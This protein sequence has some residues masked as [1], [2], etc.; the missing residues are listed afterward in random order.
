MQD[1]DENMEIPILKKSW[2]L[3]W[4][5]QKTISN[6]TFTSI[7][8][9]E[10]EFVQIVQIFIIFLTLTPKLLN[11][12]KFRVTAWKYSNIWNNNNAILPPY[13]EQFSKVPE[14]FDTKFYNFLITYFDVRHD[15]TSPGH[16]W[17]V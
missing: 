13:N 17:K 4:Y 2:L 7:K 10:S 6:S 5:W 15:G 8:L 3:S 11:A 16:F 14:V 1:D 12:E 9:Y